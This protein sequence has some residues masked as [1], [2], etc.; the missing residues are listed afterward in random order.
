M[1]FQSEQSSTESFV[2]K[3]ISKNSSPKYLALMN[4]LI[5]GI[6]TFIIGLIIKGSWQQIIIATLF[7]CLT[8]YYIIFKTIQIFIYRKIKLIYKFIYNTKA[9]K[10][11]E[12]FYNKI[13]PQKSIDEVSKDVLRWGIEKRQAIDS[14]EKNEKYRREFLNNLSHEFKTPIFTTQGY[15]ETLING[16]K[17]NPQLLDKFL[18]NANR[19][20]NRLAELAKDL[21]Q[22]SNLEFGM[23]K[24]EYSSFII[25]ELISEIYEELS[26][27]AEEKHTNL[28]F[29]KGTNLPIAVYADRN[30]IRQVLVNLIENAIKYGKDYGTI[31]SGVYLLDDG[32]VY[33]EISD[34]GPGI[35]QE[36][37][38][39]IFERFYR[40][41]R[42]RSRDV[43]GTGLGLA[44]VK[45]IIDAHQH[46]I[47]V[48]S[49][50][51]VGSSFG[52]TL[53]KA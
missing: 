44:I 28:T 1:N 14:L 48:R 39:R 52:F 34:D 36:H 30:R 10:K 31:T 3:L 17:D 51:D 13:L 9:N 41:D 8:S 25:Q 45:H 23:T 21:D 18:N 53:N 5:I 22:I 42:N 32:H 47:N 2:N 40:V 26:I 19:G 16:A 38:T 43:G 7:I 46:T 49:K 15:I 37:L 35:P 11:E 33:T 6:L 24:M 20:I 4:A 50:V 12:F 27:K 29:K